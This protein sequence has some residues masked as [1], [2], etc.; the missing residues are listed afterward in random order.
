VSTSFSSHWG[1]I[2]TVNGHGRLVLASASPRRRRLLALLGVPFDVRAVDVDES[3]GADE[4]ATAVAARL[5]ATKAVAASERRADSAVLAADT[6][7][8][9]E[10]DVL[11]KPMDPADALAMLG[12]LS[13]RAHDVITG[14]AVARNGS[15]V[16]ELTART[17]VHMRDYDC[18]DVDRYIASGRPFDKAGAY[19]IQDEDFHPVARIEGCYP[20]VVG[21]PLCEVARGL[22]AVGLRPTPPVAEVEPPC[23]LCEQSRGLDW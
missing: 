14:V 17:V 1:T 10:G 15:V 5:A 18:E 16:F 7:V 6:V 20:N 9:L 21:L 19:G 2:R 13:G 12:R 11:G 8:T 4:D 23:S 3:V 22:R